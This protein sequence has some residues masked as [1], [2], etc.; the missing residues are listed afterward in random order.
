MNISTCSER[1]LKTN[2]RIA[3]LTLFVIGQTISAY[4]QQTATSSVAAQI[5]VARSHPGW[6]CQVWMK[7]PAQSVRRFYPDDPDDGGFIKEVTKDEIVVARINEGRDE[8]RTPIL[9]SL[10]F[11]GKFFTKVDVVRWETIHRIPIGQIAE[12][13][14][15]EAADANERL[16]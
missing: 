8:Y 2:L 14:L 16:H 10:P 5:N 7:T 11:V 6:W 4:S 12:I 15:F 3:A 1:S 13:K 9:G